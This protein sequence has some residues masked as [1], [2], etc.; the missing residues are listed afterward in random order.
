MELAR[1]DLNGWPWDELRPDGDVEIAE[2]IVDKF[3]LIDAPWFMCKLFFC[4]NFTAWED[5]GTLQGP[6]LPQV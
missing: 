1:G 2:E 3:R 6:Q 5:D 4:Y